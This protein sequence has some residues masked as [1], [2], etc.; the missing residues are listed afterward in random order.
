[1]FDEATAMH[2]TPVGGGVDETIVND[3][4][5]KCDNFP[6]VPVTLTLNVPV[7]P[8]AKDLKVKVEDPVPPEDKVTFAGLTLQLGQL[9]QSGGGDVERLT[10]PLNPFTL[11]SMIDEVAVEPC[12]TFWEAGLAEMEKSGVGAAV[13][14]KDRNTEWER[15]PL[16]PFTATL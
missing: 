13:T 1:M 11:L 5:V 3:G 9:G 16:V 6:L 14:V 4:I 2:T 12:C 8:G 15:L 10:V 7:G